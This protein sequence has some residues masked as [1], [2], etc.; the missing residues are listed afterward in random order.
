MSVAAQRE[1]LE[2]GP[3]MKVWPSL[4]GHVVHH[5][6]Y[7]ALE[8]VVDQWGLILGLLQVIYYYNKPSPKWVFHCTPEDLPVIDGLWQR[9][10]PRA[11]SGSRRVKNSKFQRF[12]LIMSGVASVDIYFSVD[13]KIYLQ[14]MCAI[15]STEVFVYT[16]VQQITN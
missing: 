4:K 11:S 5:V 10:R 1:M 9:H 15:Q 3:G 2:E 14:D 13:I 12:S 8:K 6:S 16:S 7:S